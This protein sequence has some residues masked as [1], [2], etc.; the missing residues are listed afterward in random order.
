M[1]RRAP[2]APRPD[3]RSPPA[4]PLRFAPVSVV[5]GR[6]WRQCSASPCVARWCV[7]W[8]DTAQL[9]QIKSGRRRQRHV[10]R[11]PRK[12][13]RICECD[14]GVLYHLPKAETRH[15]A[16]LP[17]YRGQIARVNAS[18]TFATRLESLRYYLKQ[19]TRTA[20]MIGEAMML[21]RSV[22]DEIVQTH[23]HRHA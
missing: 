13:S 12:P 20:F 21:D 8:D 14:D 16:V 2:V 11:V 6:R 4:S 15:N 22:H 7:I 3:G 17:R 19:G 9:A 10:S 23:R 18:G 1:A 5:R